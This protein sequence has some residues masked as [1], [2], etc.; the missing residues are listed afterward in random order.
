MYMAS[1]PWL[2][3]YLKYRPFS[4]VMFISADKFV[5]AEVATGFLVILG[6]AVTLVLYLEELAIVTL[7][8]SRDLLLNLFHLGF[9]VS[10]TRVGGVVRVIFRSILSGKGV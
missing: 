2:E 1:G 3:L 5:I 9:A 7:H 10:L 8:E 6:V 4:V